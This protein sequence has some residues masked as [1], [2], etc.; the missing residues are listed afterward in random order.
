MRVNDCSNEA[1]LL[2]QHHP[3]LLARVATLT[4]FHQISS[5]FDRAFII[6]RKH[7]LQIPQ[8]LEFTCAKFLLLAIPIV[9][10]RFLNV[11][12]TLVILLDAI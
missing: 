11:A 1:N 3:T 7:F 4:N 5:S 12:N 8:D 2:V 9:Y 6:S 10:N